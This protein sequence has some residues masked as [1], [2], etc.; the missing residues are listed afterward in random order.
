MLYVVH[1][2]SK[3]QTRLS[4]RTT[5]TILGLAS[6]ELGSGTEAAIFCL[7]TYTTSCSL[8]ETNPTSLNKRLQRNTQSSLQT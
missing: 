6:S 5:K 1:G 4:D 7:A 2:V 3:S 8:G